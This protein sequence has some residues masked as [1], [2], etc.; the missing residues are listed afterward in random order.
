MTVVF[1]F[2]H[3][4]GKVKGEKIS[5]GIPKNFKFTKIPIK[6]PKQFPPVPHHSNEIADGIYGFQHMKIFKKKIIIFR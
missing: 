6:S 1:P 3:P 4:F 5:D 2:F